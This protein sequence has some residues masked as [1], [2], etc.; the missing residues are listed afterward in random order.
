MEPFRNV[1]LAVDVM[2]GRIGSGALPR[3]VETAAV[4]ADALRRATPGA[5]LTLLAVVDVHGDADLRGELVALARQRL[6]QVVAPAAG[7]V[8]EL[9]VAE[10]RP[11]VEIVR[12]VQS[13]AH[14][15]VVVGARP[16]TLLR[17]AIAGSVAIQLLRKAPC[18]VLVAPRRRLM[19][20]FVV[21]SAAARQP[22]LP[23]VLAA[24]ALLC[25]LRNAAEWHVFHCPEYPDAG[26]LHLRRRPAEEIE[27]YER[28]ERERA[29]AELLEAST[30][31]AGQA[32]VKPRLWTSEGLPAEQI[33]LASQQLHADLLVVG[34]VGRR[35]LPGVLIGNTADRVLQ[36]VDCAVLAVKPDDF[37]SP[38]GPS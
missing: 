36:D 5:R 34:T 37:D 11:A 18:P 24:S 38:I 7:G 17:R 12:R 27:A 23:K 9:V 15:L 32:G 4:T 13:G 30:A 33:V 14:D 16:S 26:S 2:D 6:Q 8:D 31:L 3:E 29:R 35:G 22:L 25:R 28:A 19:D 10:G 20:P 1:L 21:V